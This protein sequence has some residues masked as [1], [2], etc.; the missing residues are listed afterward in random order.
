MTKGIDIGHHVTLN[1]SH[2]VGLQVCMML[3]CHTLSQI[4]L[5]NPKEGVK[6]AN[7]TLL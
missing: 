5:F 3:I 7:I 2:T 1:I 6:T 4:N